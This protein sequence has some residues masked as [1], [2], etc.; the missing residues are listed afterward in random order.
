MYGVGFRIDAYCI[1]IVQ[2]TL[3]WVEWEPIDRLCSHPDLSGSTCLLAL[4]L[5][6]G[7]FLRLLFWWYLARYFY[8]IPFLLWKAPYPTI[9][10]W[11]KTPPSY[12]SYNA[13]GMSIWL[14]MIYGNW[15]PMRLPASR[16]VKVHFP[17]N[18][19]YF[20]SRAMIRTLST[21]FCEDWRS[22]KCSVGLSLSGALNI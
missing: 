11:V 9:L 3:L 19:K 8:S 18:E 17:V 21:S 20:V 15:L 13:F 4:W 10:R 5:G 22:C 2:L 1:V 7:A 14:I 6:K 12:A 16:L